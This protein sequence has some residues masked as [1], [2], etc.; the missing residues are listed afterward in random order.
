M[1][2]ASKYNKGTFTFEI[3]EHFKYQRLEDLAEKCGLDTIHK[4]NSI[5]INSKSQYGENG[6]IATDNCLVNMPKHLTND[7]RNM[8]SDDE[9][10]QAVN[11]GLFGFKIRTYTND[12]GLFYSVK[13]IDIIPEEVF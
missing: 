8:L 4:V 5:F 2:I 1:G 10:I 13:W 9:L 7:L 3:P 12:K 6:V 11:A